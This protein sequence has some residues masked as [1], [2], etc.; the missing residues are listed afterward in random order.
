MIDVRKHTTFEQR[1]NSW[2]DGNSTNDYAFICFDGKTYGNGGCCKW[3]TLALG[4]LNWLK[5]NTPEPEPD[6]KDQQCP[7]T[8]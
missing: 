8:P 7:T 4:W 2:V 5:Q 6:Q 3:D 1:G